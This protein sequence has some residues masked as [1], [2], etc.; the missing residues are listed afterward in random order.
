MTNKAK[1]VIQ[2][3]AGIISIAAV[4]LVS[5]YF[6]NLYRQVSVSYQNIDSISLY[7]LSNDRERGSIAKETILNGES[8]S[9]E[10]EKRYLIVYTADKDY[11]SGEIIIDEDTQKISI[12]PDYSEKKK[13]L[14]VDQSLSEFNKIISSDFKNI[15]LYDIQKG[16]LINKGNWYLTK[17]KYRDSEDQVNS[18][19]LVVGLHKES[20]GWKVI[21]K[22]HIYFSKINY[23]TIPDN[24]LDVANRY[25]L[26]LSIDIN[27]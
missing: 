1:K 24:I 6:M 25:S 9:L 16:I 23:P 3:L 5:L 14:L 2:V 4:V 18:D 13:Q 15:N 12:D 17:L 21:L 27:N 26:G 7:S 8:L 22:P 20:T 19:T 10:K 11:E